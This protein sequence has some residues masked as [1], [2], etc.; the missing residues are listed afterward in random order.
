MNKL[1]A[2]FLGTFCLV[3]AGAGAIVV[4]QTTTGGVSHVGIAL[5]F[6]LVVMAMAYAFGDVSGSHINPA[7]TLAFVAAGRFKVADATGY[8]IA[9]VAGALA[10]AGLLRLLFP[11]AATLGQTKPMGNPWQSFGLEIVLTFMLMLVVL[12]VSSGAKEKGIMAGIAV[13]GTVGLAA[14]FG[15][16]IS[17]ASM[18]PAR[19]IGPALVAGDLGSLWVYLAAP[20]LGALLAVPAH[21]LVFGGSTAPRA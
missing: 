12:C 16:P 21:R 18:N 2:E 10:A 19:S 14:L 6:G 11:Y 4:N 7:V 17:G 1:T 9:Q 20:V 5:V 3:F 13:G 8:I 15:G